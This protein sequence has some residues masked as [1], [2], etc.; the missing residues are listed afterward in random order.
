MRCFPSNPNPSLLPSFSAAHTDLYNLKHPVVETLSRAMPW[1]RACYSQ[2][3]QKGQTQG[4]PGAA[5]SRRCRAGRAGLR[6]GQVAGRRLFPQP[7]GNETSPAATR[8][9]LTATTSVLSP[10][11]RHTTSDTEKTALLPQT[12]THLFCSSWGI[13]SKSNYI[14]QLTFISLPPFPLKKMMWWTVSPKVLLLTH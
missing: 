11:I 14:T 9:P 3:G 7:F 5:A 2:P 10:L 13:L 6:P 4:M 8:W 12:E 1:P